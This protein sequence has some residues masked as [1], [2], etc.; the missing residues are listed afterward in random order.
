VFN[1]P[2]HHRVHHA[3]NAEYLD[4]N[5][6]GV[7]II[8]DRLFGTLRAERDE[9]PCRYGLVEPLRSNNPVTIAFHEW[10]ALARELSTAR[11]MEQ[12]WRALFGPPSPALRHQRAVRPQTGELEGAR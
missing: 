6:G 5:Y 12:A 4:A 11:S 10:L 1:T 7:L 8:F 3:A 2:S 9:I